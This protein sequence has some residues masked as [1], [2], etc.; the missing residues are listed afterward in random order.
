MFI[1][2]VTFLIVVGE[3]TGDGLYIYIHEMYL[4]CMIVCVPIGIG[5]IVAAYMEGNTN[6][7]PRKRDKFL[8]KVQDILAGVLIFAMVFGIMI[9]W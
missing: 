7:W 1:I 6:G 2:M 4:A 8:A 9:V 3:S 5:C